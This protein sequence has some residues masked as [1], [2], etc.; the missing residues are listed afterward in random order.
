ME[1]R[2]A[3][4]FDWEWGPYT[5]QLGKARAL[6]VYIYIYIRYIDVPYVCLKHFN[7]FFFKL[8]T[9]YPDLPTSKL[10]QHIAVGK[11]PT[12]SSSF[13]LINNDI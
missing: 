9:I 11:L 4:T 6:R 3:T 13:N 7:H 8:A 10:Q 1:C 5:L 2:V 12:Y